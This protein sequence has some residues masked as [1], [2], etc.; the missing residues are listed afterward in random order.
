MQY[1]YLCRLFLDAQLTVCSWAKPENFYV[2]D[3][4]LNAI[5]ER[6]AVRVALGFD[7]DTS[8]DGGK[9]TGRVIHEHYVTVARAVFLD[10]GKFTQY[11]NTDLKFLAG[12]VKN[13]IIK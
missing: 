5:K 13:R 11:S 3:L 9:T 10:S 1:T 12:V 8:E 7:K 6:P 2:T 4:L